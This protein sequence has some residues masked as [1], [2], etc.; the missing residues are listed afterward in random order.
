MAGIL[1]RAGYSTLTA[2]GMSRK[3]LPVTARKGAGPIPAR[4][5]TDHEPKPGWRPILI[6]AVSIG[7]VDWTTKALVAASIPLGQLVEVVDNRVALWHVRN[8][9]MILGLFGDLPL[10]Y[11]KILAAMLAI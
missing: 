3:K 5:R 1:K 8:P 7:I 2:T 11:R 6:L 10:T 4:R 9:A